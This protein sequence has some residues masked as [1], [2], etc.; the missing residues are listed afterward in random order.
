MLSRLV[1]AFL[2]RSKC[3]FISWLQSLSEVILE[4]RKIKTDTVYTFS[5]SVCHE[6]MGLDAMILVLDSLKSFL[7]IAFQRCGANILC[8]F[9]LHP[10][11]PWEW[12]QPNGC[13]VS[14]WSVLRAYVGGL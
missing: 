9:F 13:Q 6:V 11:H 5:P 10:E 14:F 7:S 3:L 12:L 2:P 1:I 4:S 8:F